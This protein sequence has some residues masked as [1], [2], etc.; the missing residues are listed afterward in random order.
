MCANL[1]HKVGLAAS[2]SKMTG[3]ITGKNKCVEYSTE[4]TAIKWLKNV[5][6]G[7]AVAAAA[8]I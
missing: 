1:T 7:M 8:D 5:G 4:P 2:I 3:R 6:T